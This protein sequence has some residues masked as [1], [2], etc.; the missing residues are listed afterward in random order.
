MSLRVSHAAECVLAGWAL[1]ALYRITLPR[2]QMHIVIIPVII[3]VA[4]VHSQTRDTLTLTLL[5]Q[6]SEVAGCVLCLSSS[7]HLDPSFLSLRVLHAAECI[8]LPAGP[9]GHYI[10]SH[11]RK[12]VT[13]CT[14][15]VV[16]P[17][18]GVHSQMRGTDSFKAI[19]SDNLIELSAETV[20]QKIKS[21][22]RN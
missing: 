9:C 2:T 16:L 5:A 21:L 22:L 15:I 4:G 1:R 13:K 7:L 11:C 20:F 3:P 17:I 14:H 19:V 8:F 6:A 18:A 12:C 10:A